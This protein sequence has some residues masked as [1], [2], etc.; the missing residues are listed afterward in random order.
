[1]NSCYDLEK[2]TKKLDLWYFWFYF[3]QL[4][5]PMPTAQLFIYFFFLFS[6]VRLLS[7]IIKLAQ[8]FLGFQIKVYKIQIYYNAHLLSPFCSARHTHSHSN[9]Y[10]SSA[11]RTKS[12]GKTPVVGERLQ[13]PRAVSQ[14]FRIKKVK[15]KQVPAPRSSPK[16]LASPMMTQISPESAPERGYREETGWSRRFPLSTDPACSR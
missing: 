1:M 14:T 10:H 15:L 9:L 11:F 4:T 2:Q 16:A 13:A 7:K 12:K 6:P 3:K 5:I 8:G